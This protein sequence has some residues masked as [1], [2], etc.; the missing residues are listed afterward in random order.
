MIENAAKEINEIIEKINN[1]SIAFGRF[2]IDPLSLS[3]QISSN[4]ILLLK[5]EGDVGKGYCHNYFTD[6]K[7]FGYKKFL[8]YNYEI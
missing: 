7:S 6:K 4:F 5:L 8:E 3:A 2:E 1:K